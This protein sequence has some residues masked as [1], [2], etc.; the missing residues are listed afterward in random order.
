MFYFFFLL[1]LPWWSTI[2]V[3]AFVMRM[4]L[5]LPLTAYSMHNAVRLKKLEPEIK[6]IA[7]ELRKEV[8]RAVKEFGWDQSKAKR[9]YIKNVSKCINVFLWIYFILSSLLL[10]WT[11]HYTKRKKILLSYCLYSCTLARSLDKCHMDLGWIL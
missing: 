11:C 5:P 7:F 8:S 2:I 6:N 9:E 4:L 3:T 10:S 1:G